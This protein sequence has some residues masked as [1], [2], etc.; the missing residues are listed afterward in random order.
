[1]TVNKGTR[2]T[3]TTSGALG[4]LRLSEV[5]EA[6]SAI[7]KVLKSKVKLTEEQSSALAKLSGHLQYVITDYTSVGRII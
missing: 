7:D 6:K 1:M 3:R 5:K 4:Q 2:V